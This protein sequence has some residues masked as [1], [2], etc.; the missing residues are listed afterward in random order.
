MVSRP[1][2]E[3]RFDKAYSRYGERQVRALNQ[4][5]SNGPV[6]DSTR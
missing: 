2:S 3:P 4:A 5:C 6:A 1:N